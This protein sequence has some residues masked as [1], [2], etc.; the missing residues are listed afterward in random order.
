MSDNAMDQQ[1]KQ[2]VLTW[3]TQGYLF[4]QI[5]VFLVAEGYSEEY[6]RKITDEAIGDLHDTSLPY[7]GGLK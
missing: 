5:V 4:K 6:S 2:L 3:Y 7:I 1:V